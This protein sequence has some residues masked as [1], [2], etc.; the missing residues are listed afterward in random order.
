MDE[1]QII[2]KQ[3]TIQELENASSI[4]EKC[5]ESRANETIIPII[6]I[7]ECHDE[8]YSDLS[9]PDTVSEKEFPEIT[10]SLCRTKQPLEK[11]IDPPSANSSKSGNASY[12]NKYPE[13]RLL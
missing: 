3:C 11:I 5:Y 10:C 13:I 4:T 12:Y 7:D 2:P 6:K 8:N 1:I 9:N